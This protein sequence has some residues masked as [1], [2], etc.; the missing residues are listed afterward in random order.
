MGIKHLKSVI[1]LSFLTSA[2]FIS[3]S[4]LAEEN[5]TII[6]TNIWESKSSSEIKLYDNNSTIIENQ[7]FLYSNCL[8]YHTEMRDRLVI[9]QKSIWRVGDW[10]GNNPTIE[11]TAFQIM[12][13]GKQENLWSIKEEADEGKLDCNFYHTI[14]YGCCSACPNHRL[15]NPKTGKLIM[16]YSDELLSVEIPNSPLKRYIGYKPSETITT[17]SWEK[18]KKHIGT[19]TYSSPDKIIQRI[20]LRMVGDS[21]DKFGIGFAHISIEPGG[22]DQKLSKNT[23]DLW[24]SNS[25]K[26]PA[27]LTNFKIK[28]VFYAGYTIVIPVRKDAL[29]FSKTKFDCYEIIKVMDTAQP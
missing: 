19:L 1:C 4:V 25:S 16:E 3:N 24:E 15:Y 10:E 14:W 5:N 22:K 6:V 8:R 27:R 2:I 26:D 17:N 7:T 29:F 20:A 23:L 13:D 28:I 11:A 12:P 18:D 9:L 21:E